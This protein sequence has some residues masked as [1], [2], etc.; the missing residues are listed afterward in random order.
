MRS[1]A[2]VIL[3][4]GVCSLGVASCTPPPEPN[5]SPS[6]STPQTWDPE[7]WEP[8]VKITPKTF[9]EEERWAL[10]AEWL[11]RAEPSDGPPGDVQLIRWLDG[12]KEYSETMAQCLTER[13]FPA[14]P[15]TL[16]VTFPDGGIPSEQDDAL[17]IAWYMCEAQYTLDPRF[18][19]EYTDEQLGVL[20]DYFEQYYIP[21]MKAHDQPVAD[22]DK[23]TR[24][25][26]IANSTGENADPWWPYP[27]AAIPEH[28]KKACPE[29][30]PDKA[31]YG[32]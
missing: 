4:V 28:V 19:G 12:T 8:T 23:P 3:L 25:V 31:L 15:D 13:G 30:P 11:K 9:T 22:K 17:D 29:L 7:A 26:Y 10:R 6:P 5:A 21:C 24:D 2:L 27:I 20:Y 14:E 1:L 18:H 32:G 16:G